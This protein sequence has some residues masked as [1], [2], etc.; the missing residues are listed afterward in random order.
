MVANLVIT[1]F[2]FP[3]LQKH[4]AML[5]SYLE[6]STYLCGDRLTNADIVMAFGMVSLRSGVD[7]T[8]LGAWKKGTFQETYPNLWAYAGRI[9]QEPAWQK[10]VQ[11]IEALEGSYSVL[12]S[13]Q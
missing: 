4:F 8:Q 13:T 9:E 10:S 11:K 2:S 3:T 5:D 6:K 7:L 1:Q 12:P